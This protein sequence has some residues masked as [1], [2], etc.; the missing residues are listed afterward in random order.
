MVL[1]LLNL[2][3][4][5]IYYQSQLLF[6]RW[7]IVYMRVSILIHHCKET[8]YV[9]NPEKSKSLQKSS[10]TPLVNFFTSGV[11]DNKLFIFESIVVIVMSKTLKKTKVYWLALPSFEPADTSLIPHSSSHLIPNDFFSIKWVNLIEFPCKHTS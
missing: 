6:Y 5:L 1:A 9:K 7:K 10:V 3:L 8:C 11:T 2:L 4:S